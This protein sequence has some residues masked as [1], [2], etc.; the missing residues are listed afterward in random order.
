MFQS[1]TSVP[2]LV[3]SPVRTLS[4]PAIPE[5]PDFVTLLTLLLELPTP[6]PPPGV[7]L[8]AASICFLL[9]PCSRMAACWLS[10]PPAM[11]PTL[12]LTA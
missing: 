10:V 8:L 4:S 3:V 5:I 9:M 7:V 11:N 2:A 6:A 12:P 1:F